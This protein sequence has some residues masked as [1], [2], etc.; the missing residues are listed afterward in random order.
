MEKDSTIHEFKLWL[1]KKGIDYNQYP[2]FEVMIIESV[3]IYITEHTIQEDFFVRNQLLY[4][5]WKEGLVLLLS[6][7][8]THAVFRGLKLSDYQHIANQLIFKIELDEI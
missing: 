6:N 3:E 5:I 7:V 8:H 4:E 1:L 2:L